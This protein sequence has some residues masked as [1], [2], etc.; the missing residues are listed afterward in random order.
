MSR[1]AI[2]VASSNFDLKVVKTDEPVSDALNFFIPF[3]SMMA[4]IT[5]NPYT[6]LINKLTFLF[7]SEMVL[8]HLSAL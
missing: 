5:R 6:L 8:T 1:L 7:S 4:L 2:E 3:T